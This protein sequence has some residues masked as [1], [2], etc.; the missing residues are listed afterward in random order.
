VNGYVELKPDFAEAHVNLGNALM[1]QGQNADAEAEFRKAVGLKP[2]LPQPHINLGNLLSKAGKFR[3]AEAAYR[4]AIALDPRDF[5]AHSNLGS[6]LFDEMNSPAGAEPLFRKVIELKPDLAQGHFDLGCV[7]YETGRSAEAEGYW[8]RAIELYA[9]LPEKDRTPWDSECHARTHCNIGKALQRRG[10]FQEAVAEYRLCHE[11]GSK[12]SGW[13][14]PSAQWVRDAER[15]AD[16]ASRLSTLLNDGFQPADR[17]EGFLFV[18]VCTDTKHHAAAARFYTA[19]FAAQPNPAE[20]LVKHRYD[21]ACAAALTGCGQGVDAGKLDDTERAGL[22]RQALDWLRAE[23]AAVS[24]LGDTQGGRQ[25]QRR[26]MVHWQNDPDF[27]GVR[28]ITALAKLP[29]AEAVAWLK[30]W[31]DVAD[32]LK[33]TEEA[34]AR[35]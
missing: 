21:A 17:D 7:L 1:R 19:A 35:E 16:L 34:L 3:E 12:L 27:A 30:L 20:E 13:S 9:K 22:R 18:E 25:E 28:D 5:M 8:R 29:D 4:R 23:Y 14:E 31:A 11:L 6:L 2:S 26:A 10:Q 32:L 15:M 24:K 33:R